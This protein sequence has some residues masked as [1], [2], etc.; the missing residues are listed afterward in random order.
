MD[1]IDGHLEEESM[2]ERIRSP[3]A[4]LDRAEVWEEEHFRRRCHDVIEL[5]RPEM[6]DEHKSNPFGYREHHSLELQRVD[7]LLKTYPSG[8]L[9]YM[10]ILGQ[11]SQWRIMAFRRHEPP[12]TL[13]EPLLGTLDEAVHHIFLLRLQ[14]LQA[15]VEGERL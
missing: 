13:E 3:R 9:R 6:L 1:G 12:I 10:P 2:S 7:R 8:G 4:Y 5:F 15:F 11:D 14:A